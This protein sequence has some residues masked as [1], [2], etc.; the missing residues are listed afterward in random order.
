MKKCDV[1]P[2]FDAVQA[3]MLVLKYFSFPSMGN[4][5]DRAATPPSLPRTSIVELQL[6]PRLIGCPLSFW[7]REKKPKY[8]RCCYS[9]SRHLQAYMLCQKWSFTPAS[10]CKGRAPPFAKE[11]QI[12][13]LARL[14]YRK[15]RKAGPLSLQCPALYCYPGDC[16]GISWAAS[17]S[18]FPSLSGRWAAPGPSS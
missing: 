5:L 1:P 14:L 10:L 6:R 2:P 13:S 4:V 9:A 11:Q 3:V 18:L 12:L 15:H 16:S 17:T 7:R 8:H